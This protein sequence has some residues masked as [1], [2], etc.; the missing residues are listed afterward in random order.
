MRLK[1]HYRQITELLSSQSDKHRLSQS[2]YHH[3]QQETIPKIIKNRW[4]IQSPISSGS[5]GCIYQGLNLVTNENVAIKFE[6][7]TSNHPQLYKE[8]QIYRSI[9]G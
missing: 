6:S 5:F 1:S 9:E 3:K 4:S 2:D 7:K 8:S